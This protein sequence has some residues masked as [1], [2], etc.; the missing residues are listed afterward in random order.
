MKVIIP[1]PQFFLLT[2]LLSPNPKPHPHVK[3]AV[4]LNLLGET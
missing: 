3:S 4:M 2:S 1:K